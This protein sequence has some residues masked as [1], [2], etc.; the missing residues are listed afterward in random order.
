MPELNTEYTDEMDALKATDG[1]T[2]VKTS[3]EC[4][5]AYVLMCERH[6]IGRVRVS[7]LKSDKWTPREAFRNDRSP[8][9]S[10]IKVTYHS[11][12]LA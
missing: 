7:M 12:H 10:Y 5:V 6:N 8:E 4:G 2:E 3:Q 9:H 11:E 1:V